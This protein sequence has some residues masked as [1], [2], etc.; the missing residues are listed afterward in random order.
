MDEIFDYIEENDIK[1]IRMQFCDLFGQS[2]SIAISRDQLNVAVELG[3]LFDASAVPGYGAKRHSELVLHPDLST[4][5]ILPW[6]PQRG[7]VARILCDVRYPDGKSVEGDCRHLLKEQIKKAEEKGYYFDVGAKCQFFLFRLGENGEPTREPVDQ[8]GY[9]D[10]APFDQ[11]ENTRR[12]IIFTLE[13]MGFEIESSHHEEAHGQHEIDFK[14]RNALESA[15]NIMT[16]KTVVKSIA[17]R[18]GLHAT[19]MP[20]PLNGQPGSGMHINIALQKKGK[21]L[22]MNEAG[23][24]TQSAEHFAGG[25]LEHLPAITAIANP[26]V[27]SYKRLSGMVEGEKENFSILRF[28]ASLSKNQRIELRSPDPSCNPYLTLGLVLAAGIEGIENKRDL[29]QTYKEIKL[30]DTLKEALDAMKEDTL[31]AEVLGNE[32]LNNYLKA[33]KAEWQ[34]YSAFVHDWEMERYFLSL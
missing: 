29:P 16:F 24:L 7:K 26:V 23:V 31:I 10:L 13:E 34:E 6:R 8:A 4:I 27:N 30:P 5:Q 28:P 15:D 33:K 22:F 19:F 32:T 3:V 11:G 17:Q 14:Y 21:N 9:F 18:N 2:R 12:E 25:V 1:F 20:K